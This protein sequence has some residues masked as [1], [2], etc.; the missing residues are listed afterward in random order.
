MAKCRDCGEPVTW[1]TIRGGKSDGKKR[2]F[3]PNGSDQGRYGL[4]GTDE[5]D[6]YDKQLIEAVYYEDPLKGLA[7]HDQ[8]FTAHYTTCSAAKGGKN[9]PIPAGPKVFAMVQIG[10]DDYTGY[11]AKGAAKTEEVPF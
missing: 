10:G 2:C 8:L 5:K 3:D 4:R 7:E 9:L 11:L 1:A 6:Q